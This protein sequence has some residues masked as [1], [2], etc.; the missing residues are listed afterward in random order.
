[1]ESSPEQPFFVRGRG[2][3]S[4]SPK[5]TEKMLQ[6]PCGTLAVGDI[7]ITLTRHVRS[8]SISRSSGGP[9]TQHHS[10]PPSAGRGSKSK[11][12]TTR[13]YGTYAKSRNSSTNSILKSSHS[14][15]QKGNNGARGNG[16]KLVSGPATNLADVNNTAGVNNSIIRQ[17]EKINSPAHPQQLPPPPSAAAVAAVAIEIKEDRQLRNVGKDVDIP[18]ATLSSTTTTTLQSGS[19][20]PTTTSSGSGRFETHTK[21]A[22]LEAAITT[23]TASSSSSTASGSKRKSISPSPVGPQ[24]CS[25]E[26][27]DAQDGESSMMPPSPK[28]RRWSAPD[29]IEVESQQSNVSTGNGTSST[30]RSTPSSSGNMT[31]TATMPESTAEDNNKGKESE[32]KASGN[33][34][35]KVKGNVEHTAEQS[36]RNSNSTTI[37][38]KIPNIPVEKA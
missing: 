12:G 23:T 29:Q 24:P 10:T 11:S 17:T 25:G 34:S 6:L 30:L 14:Q 27:N 33:A 28:K 16:R 2:W 13:P 32:T 15:Q 4:S 18:L 20:N 3:S 36:R 19:N 31:A 35:P 26:E 22:S 37:E 21:E 1:M 7:C 5:L 8:Q 38:M 9:T